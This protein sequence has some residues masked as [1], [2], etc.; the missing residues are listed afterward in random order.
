MMIFQ[1]DDGRMVVVVE[2]CRVGWAWRQWRGPVGLHFRRVICDN[3]ETYVDLRCRNYSV[4]VRFL[5]WGK[6]RISEVKSMCWKV[7]QKWSM[8]GYWVPSHVCVVFRSCDRFSLRFNLVDR[9]FFAGQKRYQEER[10][11]LSN[12]SRA[13]DQIMRTVH[14]K[15][16]SWFHILTSS[17]GWGVAYLDDDLIT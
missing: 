17:I 11:D 3:G 8:T 10:K 2:I 1:P 9:Y 14:I 15:L 7:E 12:F 5:I 6:Y 16:L 4:P 13:A